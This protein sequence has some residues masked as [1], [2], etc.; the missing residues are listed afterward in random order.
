MG[1][2]GFYAPKSGGCLREAL[3]TA[4][5]IVGCTALLLITMNY[6]VYGGSR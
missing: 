6:L 2:G 4:A 3:L 1:A 5:V